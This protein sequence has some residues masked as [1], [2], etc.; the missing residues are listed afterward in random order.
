MKTILLHPKTPHQNKNNNTRKAESEPSTKSRCTLCIT[1][2]SYSLFKDS[3]TQK[4]YPILGQINC[5]LQNLVN[6]LTRTILEK[7]PHPHG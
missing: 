7:H 6:K 3:V 2:P 1:M 4:E 5:D